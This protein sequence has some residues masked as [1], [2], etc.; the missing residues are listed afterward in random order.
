MSKTKE[1]VIIYSTVSTIIVVIFVIFLA[2]SPMSVTAGTVPAKFEVYFLTIG[3]AGNLVAYV[4]EQAISVSVKIDSEAES[5]YVE[6]PV[7]SG[8]NGFLG[9][10]EEWVA[11]GFGGTLHVNSV[12][13]VKS[14]LLLKY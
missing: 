5:P 1:N 2:F 11:W 7:I 8:K 3:S 14:L 4:P 10:K 6:A 9:K 13:K 12:E